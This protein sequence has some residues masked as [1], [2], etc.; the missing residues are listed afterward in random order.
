[1]LDALWKTPSKN[2]CVIWLPPR[3]DRRIMLS[4]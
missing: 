2:F 4:C 3:M 1:L